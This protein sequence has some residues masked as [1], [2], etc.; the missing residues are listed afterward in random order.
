MLSGAVVGGAFSPLETNEDAPGTA[1]AEAASGRA[2]RSVGGDDGR[3]GTPGIDCRPGT[4]GKENIPAT[5]GNDGAVVSGA[6][7]PKSRKYAEDS[8]VAGDDP[9]GI[10]GA[11]DGTFPN[12]AGMPRRSASVNDVPGAEA[13]IPGMPGHGCAPGTA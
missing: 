12:N 9:A 10:L 11:N 1:G 4:P 5:S 3:L 7:F 8:G 6:T 2:A 13:G